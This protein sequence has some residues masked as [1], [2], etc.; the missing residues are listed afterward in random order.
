MPEQMTRES[1][2]TA[3]VVLATTPA[4]GLSCADGTLLDRLNDQLATLP[5]RDVHVVPASGGLP[6]DLRAVARVARQS[7]GAVVILPADLVAHTESL[8]LLLEHPS[9]DT[10]ALVSPDRP[11]GPLH[12]P[13]R[14]QGG[15]VAAAGSSFHTVPESNATFLSVLQVGEADLGCLADI[16]AEL[17]DLVA[18]G[19]LGPVTAIEATDLL[20]V[21]LVRSG[22]GVRGAQI[23]P[24]HCGRVTGQSSVDSAVTRLA[25]VDEARVRLDTA[26]KSDDGFFATYFVSSWTKPLVRLAARL[27]L[28]PNSVTGI[29]IGVAVMAAV[30]FTYGAR[31]A[32]VLGAVLFY[33]SFVLDCVDG[34]L[35]R[36]TRGF[37]P[38]GAWADGMA[39]RL[40][41]Y[42]VYIGLAVGF[43]AGLSNPE[44]IWYLAVGA[45]ILQAVRHAV[46]F[47]FAGAVS[48]AARVGAA[49]A[50]PPRSLM[51]PSDQGPHGLRA[52]LERDTLTRWL[53]KM[54]VLPI[55]ERTALIAVTA[56][57]FNARVTFLALLG[58]GGVALLYQLVGRIER[59]GT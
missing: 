1:T 47:S 6:D 49:W 36:Y 48:D 11:P 8:A 45:M 22:V 40:K 20:L 13:V 30:W 25:E 23:G 58:W 55:G 15:R 35:A 43:A 51:E 24:L 46:D 12:P 21:G 4:C 56:A 19:R 10:S 44:G 7:H 54:I 50:R 16:A 52:R 33:L 18:A 39:D 32:Q 27:K 34:Q 26:V 53:K 17:A 9:R 29:S 59:A 28:S 5:V 57:L 14:I 38:L 42:L 3:A 2:T 41:E 31:W 37:T